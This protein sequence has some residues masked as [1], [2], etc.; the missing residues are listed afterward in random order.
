MMPST[1]TGPIWSTGAPG[2]KNGFPRA[3][4]HVPVALLLEAALDPVGAG[5]AV[6]RIHRF[7]RIALHVGDRELAADELGDA[8]GGLRDGLVTLA[9]RHAHDTARAFETHALERRADLFVRRALAAVRGHGLLP[10][11]LHP[12]N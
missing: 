9:D 5:H 2:K 6:G 11:G 4:V 12:E 1:T 8:V 7:S 10:R 3:A